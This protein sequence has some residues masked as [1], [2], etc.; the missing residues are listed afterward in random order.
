[1]GSTA[2]LSGEIQTWWKGRDHPGRL[3]GPEEDD[4]GKER[5]REATESQ[6]EAN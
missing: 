5:M 1:M 3:L 2:H 4:R 6:T